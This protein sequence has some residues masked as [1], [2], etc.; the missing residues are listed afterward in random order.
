MQQG[1]NQ[2][3]QQQGAQKSY[4]YNGALHL[5]N[6]GNTQIKA[7]KYKE[8]LESYDRAIEN[9]RPHAGDDVRTLR[10][11]LLSNAALCQLKLKNYRKG[12]DVCEEA[13]TINPKAVKPL[14]RRGLA[15][16]GMGDFSQALLD[17]KNASAISPDDKAVTMELERLRKICKEK[18]IKE[19]EI[20]AKVKEPVAAAASSSSSATGAPTAFTPGGSASSTM[21]MPGDDD[22]AK[23]MDSMAKNPEMLN[24]AS[25]MMKNMSPEDIARMCPGQD[26]EMMKQSLKMMEENPDMIKQSMEAM[27]AMPEDER[28]KMLETA[29][30]KRAGGMGGAGGP[31]MN[32][33]FE[34]MSKNP[35]MM[36]QAMNMMSSMKPEDM[37][38]MQEMMAGADG[39]PSKAMDMMSENPDM[40]DQAA[41]M[42]QNMNPDDL[43]KMMPGSDPNQAKMLSKLMP[44]LPYL[45]KCMKIFGYCRRGFKTMFSPKGRIAIAVVVLAA[46]AAQHYNST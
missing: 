1:M 34:E 5:K 6:E 15:Y 10:L 26:P 42:M 11:A 7:E 29:K 22:M 23:A 33:A 35:E 13:L 39:D 8:A 25:Q 21:A 16:E 44:Y 38:K 24:Q 20:K 41:K 43:A 18:G 32:A 27:K 2:A 28:R 37:Q 31:D 17:V 36:N 40:L 12:L 9:L 14:Y 19:D 46:A 3:Q 30:S 45:L 4:V